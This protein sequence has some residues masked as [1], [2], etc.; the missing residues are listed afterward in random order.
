M[1]H[2]KETKAEGLAHYFTARRDAVA[3]PCARLTALKYL[4][5]RFVGRCPTLVCVALSGLRN[6]TTPKGFS[7]I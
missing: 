6:I 4:R 3:L 7:H 2:K 1:G 5:R